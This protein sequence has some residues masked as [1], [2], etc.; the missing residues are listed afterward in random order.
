MVL[1]DQAVPD[2][3][4]GRAG[5]SI[6]RSIFLDV[7][8]R[9]TRRSGS[10]PAASR[11]AWAIEQAL[12]QRAFAVI[13]VDGRGFTVAECRRLQVAGA[14]R[15]PPTPVL[16]LREPH[17]ISDRS[18]ASFRWRIEPS[19]DAAGVGGWRLRL[20][21]GRWSALSRAGASGCSELHK[22][23]ESDEGLTAMV[24]AGLSRGC[25]AGSVWACAG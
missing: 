11:R 16:L 8:E 5:T 14:G 19:L 22:K 3:Y 21:H 15:S 20:V 25:R 13:V 12:R 10:C 17:E 18:V 2:P 23:I 1:A 7:D 9:P 6:S 4:G 24:D